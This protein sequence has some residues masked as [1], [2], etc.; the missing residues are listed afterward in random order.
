MTKHV[1]FVCTGN[2]CRS[3]M[4]E[5]MF[6]QL[7]E[8]RGLAHRVTVSSAGL[9]AFDGDGAADGARRAMADRGLSL[10]EHRSRRVDSALVEEADLILVMTV[11]HRERL[12]EAFPHKADRVYTLKEYGGGED[13]SLDV[14]DPF[15]Q[16]DER[17]RSVAEEMWELLEQVLRRWEREEGGLSPEQDDNIHSPPGEPDMGQ[18]GTHAERNGTYAGGTGQ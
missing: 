17:Y 8:E 4:A 16:D 18:R 5:A 1:L 10:T 15:G 6:R 2:T 11:S 7:L 12:R 3:P 14:L 13:G 9:A